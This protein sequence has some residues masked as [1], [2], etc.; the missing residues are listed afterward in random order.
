MSNKD[1]GASLNSNELTPINF[2]NFILPKNN[3]PIIAIEKK[4]TNSI[5]DFS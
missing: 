2:K 3:P 4:K 1:A 5:D